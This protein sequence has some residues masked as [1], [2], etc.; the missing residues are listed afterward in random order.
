ML[1]F[2][3]G[4][5]R[6]GSLV[7]VLLGG[8]L[9]DIFGRATS[10]LAI[11]AIGVVGIP[12]ALALKAR[13]T[14]VLATPKPSVHPHPVSRE[15]RLWG[16][17]LGI[18]SRQ[19]KTLRHRLLACDFAA[20]ALNLVVS[21]GLVA[22]LG[23]YLDQRLGDGV[24]IAGVVLGV[25]TINGL[26][27][28]ARWL[29]DVGNLYWGQIADNVGLEKVAIAAMPVS[30][31]ALLLLALDAPLSIALPWLALTLVFL[32]AAV[33]ALTAIAGGLATSPE[34][35]QALARFA[36]WQD[37]GAAFGPLLAFAL[38]SDFSLDWVYLSGSVILAVAMI[39]FILAFHPS[40]S[41]KTTPES[42]N[43]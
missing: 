32:A 6:F 29:A 21:G 38:T 35:P 13:D 20:F 1:G 18:S 42:R 16:L 12:A 14:A 40:A 17:A 3:S 22:T 30:I 7:G 41:F 33:I 34:R 19:P 24:A 43:K 37:T 9:F 11:A 25:A 5:Q 27:Q 28:A 8:I 2:F 36:T 15:S 26:L 10:F 4:G 23:Y 31:A 39:A